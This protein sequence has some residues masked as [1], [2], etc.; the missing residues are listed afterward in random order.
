[1]SEISI[2]VPIY[3]VEAYLG[4]CVDS[5]L[6]QSFVD[7]EVLLVDDGSPDNCGKICNE[8]ALKDPRIKVIHK[9][10]GGLSD[11][12]NAG[13][14]W[15]LTN[16]TSEW[17]T[18]I[19]SDDWVHPQYLE[20]LYKAVKETD[21]KVSICN[22]KRSSNMEVFEK[23]DNIKTTVW[24]TNDFYTENNVNAVV[25]WGKLY[26]KELFT[27]VRY[28]VGKLHEDEFTTHKL[29]FKDNDV[30]FVDY[31]LYYYFTNNEG[32]MRSQWNL[33]NF[34]A[35]PF[36]Q[37]MDA[38]YERIAYF[39]SIGNDYMYRWQAKFY[40]ENIRLYFDIIR[41][42]NENNDYLNVLRKRLRKA[43]FEFKKL[44]LIS[45]KDDVYYYEIAFPRVMPYYWFLKKIFSNK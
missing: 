3:M 7:F 12:R 2:V 30:S 28:P 34:R 33:D 23:L 45:F 15:I 37:T 9:K 40:I 21:T 25:A 36:E 5:I 31:E 27:D 39:K 24:K 6:N 26:K 22:F 11:A 4:R 35:K 43:I 16:S 32:I 17:I 42:H 29:L 1:M 13:I 44:H 14:D 38:W 8:Y 10:N 20:L 18:C 41:R 19:D